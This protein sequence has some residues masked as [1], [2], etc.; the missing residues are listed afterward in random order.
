[1][2]RMLAVLRTPKTEVIKFSDFMNREKE[3]V[4]ATK[5]ATKETDVIIRKDN[6]HRKKAMTT[7]GVGFSS[8]FLTNLFMSKNLAHAEAGYQ[9][10]E[11]IMATAGIG[12]VTEKI[13]TA[14]TPVIDLVQGLAYPICFVGITI[15]CLLF[16][17]NQ[18]EKAISMIQNASLGFILVNLAPLFMKLLVGITAA[19]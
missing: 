5:K 7:A 13:V 15:G 10:Q 3:E 1:M 2:S 6:T 19:I 8:I 9:G 18:K 17:I 11:V 16:M 4:K 14:F 12:S